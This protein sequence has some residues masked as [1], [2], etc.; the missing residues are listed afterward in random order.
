MKVF[1]R[2]VLFVVV[3]PYLAVC[4]TGCALQR[5]L[6]YHPSDN[7]FS[8]QAYKLPMEEVEM[9]TEDGTKLVSWYA[10]PKEDTKPVFV[11]FHG[12]AGHL[13]MRKAD[14]WG[15]VKKGYGV[16]ALSYRG[17]GKSEGSPSEEGIYDDAQT[18]VLWLKKQGYSEDQMI[19]YGESL[20]TGVAVEMATRFAFK[21]MILESP[22]STMVEAGEVHYPFLPVSLLLLDRFE[23]IKK[24]SQVTEPLLVI[25]GTQD[26]V[27]PFS[28]GA[29]L[30]L[31]F[32]KQRKGQ[33]ILTEMIA[34]DGKG[35]NNH[36]LQWSIDQ[37]DKFAA[38][39][40]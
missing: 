26:R 6:L 16:F 23:S 1:F 27:V 37:W 29:A 21:G 25:H 30:F 15:L 39:L 36:D 17:F 11:F 18:A 38:R 40:D 32:Q 34:L 33:N 24:V 9:V 3:V 12:N 8:P 35:H 19:V 7:Q 4:M 5:T 14:Y 13:G 2:S 31:A 28:Q 10:K 22:Y 20:G